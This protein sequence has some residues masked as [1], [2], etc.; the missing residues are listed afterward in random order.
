MLGDKAWVFNF[1]ALWLTIMALAST[2][3]FVHK[4]RFAVKPVEFLRKLSVGALEFTALFTVL[5]VIPSNTSFIPQ[6]G[7]V[8]LEGRTRRYRWGA[9][10]RGSTSASSA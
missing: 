1:L 9:C 4:L 6:L 10:T 8:F 3:Y 5:N 2:A 7:L